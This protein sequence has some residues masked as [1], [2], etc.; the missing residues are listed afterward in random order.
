MPNHFSD[1]AN[2]LGAAAC[3]VFADADGLDVPD[4]SVHGRAP[5]RLRG[6]VEVQNSS[7]LAAFPRVG[8]FSGFPGVYGSVPYSAW[9]RLG[10]TFT[11]V[12]V[13]R[14][15]LA[16]PKD[17]NR[18]ATI[19]S[20]GN[21]FWWLRH[22]GVYGEP[23]RLSAVIGNPSAQFTAVVMGADDYT[24]RQWHTFA[25]QANAAVVSAWVDGVKV[26]EAAAAHP[27]GS[28]GP[29]EAL[30][31]GA[32]SF[33]GVWDRFW[34]GHVAAVVGFPT[35][36]SGVDMLAL[37]DT[38]NEVEETSD[39][40]WRLWR[41]D[42][43]RFADLFNTS[44][45]TAD[46]RIVHGLNVGHAMAAAI[47]Q[48]IDIRH[49]LTVGH[50]MA[51][52]TFLPTYVEAR[53]GLRVRH[54]VEVHA[55]SPSSYYDFDTDALYQ[56]PAGWTRRL[57]YR[58]DVRDSGIAG[59]DGRWLRLDSA[60]DNLG[61]R[62]R[63]CSVDLADGEQNVDIRALC[64]V[65]GGTG[66]QH[67]FVFRSGRDP[68]ADGSYIVGY[69]R[70]SGGRVF[71]ERYTAYGYNN[72]SNVAANVGDVG[73]QTWFWMR[74]QVVGD[75]IRVKT[76]GRWQ[77]EPSGW[78]LTYDDPGTNRPDGPYHGFGA[79]LGNITLGWDRVTVEVDP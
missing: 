55:A 32:R 69:T 9:M 30:G 78:D 14:T 6:G 23:R 35:A 5:I 54:D 71:V 8:W 12:V 19:S 4:S 45:F 64:G 50:A 25:V 47:P 28:D 37:H 43:R 70:G 29:D 34:R 49:G 62:E 1:T 79:W 77:N 21:A 58:W 48:H 72:L 38:I 26:G 39:A 40:K 66:T 13:A 46:P 33:N 65:E 68:D 67:Q 42:V 60:Q 27:G 59:D 16:D 44:R 61:G 56:V 17:Q 73:T 22:H 3:W 2:T 20:I 41:M 51:T 57:G 7:A 31:I 11:W 76:W 24:E 75:R 53:H 36:L 18:W 15:G 10:D 52:E 74:A 63:L